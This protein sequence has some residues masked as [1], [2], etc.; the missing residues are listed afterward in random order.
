[1]NSNF[2]VIATI[3]CLSA[4]TTPAVEYDTM[5]GPLTK[6]DGTSAPTLFRVPRSI[7]EIAPDPK[8]PVVTVQP[9]A[10]DVVPVSKPTALPNNSNLMYTLS[11]S[12]DRT[13][14]ISR[15]DFGNLGADSSGFPFPSCDTVV[16]TIYGAPGTTFGG[17][18]SV[19]PT[20]L[21]IATGTGNVGY[22]PL[23]KAVGR[24]NVISTTTTKLTYFGDS[25]IP[26]TVV[27][28]TTDN[29][30][31]EVSSVTTIAAAVIPIAL[32]AAPAAAAPALDAASAVPVTNLSLTTADN[33]DLYLIPLPT[34]GT[35]SAHQTCGADVSDS[36]DVQSKAA[37]GASDAA[38]VIKEAAA[39]YTQVKGGSAN[40]VKTAEK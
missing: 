7:I 5:N 26:R 23:Y 15:A 1:M 27:S 40:V 33:D 6:S 29:I 35:I 19:V 21:A 30:Q 3:A 8:I 12:H 24:D 16:L 2:T 14:T 38:A 10:L 20:E 34:K 37:Q 22:L 11:V 4:C 31:S 9:T 39:I 36:A 28:G 18:V 13:G 25:M 32:A 17:V